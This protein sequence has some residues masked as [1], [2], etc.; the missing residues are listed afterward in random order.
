VTDS[1]G[2]ELSRAEIM[3]L[4]K[5]L[6]H[7][8]LD[9]SLRPLTMLELWQELAWAVPVNFPAKLKQEYESGERTKAA[10]LYQEFLITQASLSLKNY[11]EAIVHHVLPLMQTEEHL[12]RITRE[13]L[14]DAHADGVIALELRFAP[15]LH[16]ASGLSLEKVMDAIVAGTRG[17]TVPVRL[18]VCALR[19]ETQAMAKR[20]VDLALAYREHVGLFDLAGDEHA[21]PGVLLWWAQE[22][23]RAR[24]G[25]LELDIHLWET[26]EPS[27][28]DLARLAEFEL[29]RL[30][31]GMRGDRQENR[32]LEVCPSS[33]LVTGQVKRLAEHP[34]DRLFRQNKKV[35]V[36]TDGTLFTRSDLSGEYSLLHKQFGWGKQEF[37]AV[38]LTALDASTFSAE[39]KNEI[40]S[41]LMKGY[42]S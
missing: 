8:H 21:N 15:Q 34:I 17:S 5:V 38:N 26:D 28:E 11:V 14:E 23:V 2:T 7:E 31:H 30:G 32:I 19:H 3:A 4:P 18:I 40:R 25:G 33:N 27:E 37:L 36:N 10:D 20:L 9:C 29:S 41:R 39:C 24:A 1:K 35:T 6:L 13:R 12:T 42:Q 16:T 22:A